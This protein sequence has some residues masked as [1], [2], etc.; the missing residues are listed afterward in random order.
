MLIHDTTYTPEDQEA[1]RLR[2]HSS[3]LDAARAAARCHASMLVMFHYDQDYSDEQID[4]LRNRCRELL[5]SEPDGRQ[6]ALIA[7]HEGLTLSIAPA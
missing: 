4:A 3:I 1:R 5:D 7:A 6:V 2:G